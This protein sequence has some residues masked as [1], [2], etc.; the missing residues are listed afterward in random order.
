MLYFTSNR[1]EVTH[2]DFIKHYLRTEGNASEEV[3][4]NDFDSLKGFIT[5][6]LQ[7]NGEIYS[8]K[9]EYTMNSQQSGLTWMREN[10]KYFLSIIKTTI[11]TK[12][13]P[14]AFVHFSIQSAD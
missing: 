7:M 14:S 3:S 9:S 4:K 13:M 1:S 11:K 12:T 10:V 6:L 2:I 8:P 5:S